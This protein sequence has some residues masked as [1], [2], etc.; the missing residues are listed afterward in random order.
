MVIVFDMALYWVVLGLVLV[1]EL[2]AASHHG[3]SQSRLLAAIGKSMDMCR[4]ESKLTTDMLQDWSKI[5][6]KDF[7]VKHREFGCT[8]KCMAKNLAVLEDGAMHDGKLSGFM[9]NI[10]DDEDM[11]SKS[12]NLILNCHNQAADIDDECDR[13]AQTFRC[14]KAG[15]DTAGHTPYAELIR[16]LLNE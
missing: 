8:L 4:E 9:S 12:T 15:L 3:V 11:T 1:A 2:E 10:H 7:E 5:W 13:F 14:Y 6:E 16:D